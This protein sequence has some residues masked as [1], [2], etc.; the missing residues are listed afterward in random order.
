MYR[1]VHET[2][3]G[4]ASKIWVL[5]TE[6]LYD[7]KRSCSI[8]R[9]RK[10]KNISLTQH[11]SFITHSCEDLCKN[12]NSLAACTNTVTRQLFESMQFPKLLIEGIFFKFITENCSSVIYSNS[13][14]T[15]IIILITYFYLKTRLF[16]LFFLT[17]LAV[18]S[19]LSK[20]LLLCNFVKVLSSKKM[21]CFLLHIIY[22]ISVR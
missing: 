20:N 22:N 21:I 18:T 8:P 19:H 7:I 10:T 12:Y 9:S 1:K 11:Y 3:I 17:E 15:K 4:K 5:D 13:T 14:W 2:G 16:C 6:K